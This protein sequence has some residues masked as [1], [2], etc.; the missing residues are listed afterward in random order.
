MDCYGTLMLGVRGCT[1][2]CSF[3]GECGYFLVY[4]PM[5]RRQTMQ[6]FS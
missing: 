5:I 3:T 1:M 6:L 2:K 4:A